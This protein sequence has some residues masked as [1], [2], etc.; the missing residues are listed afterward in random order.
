MSRSS[1]PPGLYWIGPTPEIVLSRLQSNITGAQARENRRKTEAEI[2]QVLAEIKTQGHKTTSKDTGTAVCLLRPRRRR[3]LF[4]TQSFQ[5]YYAI[6]CISSSVSFTITID[7]ISLITLTAGDMQT[8]SLLTEV[9]FYSR[10]DVAKL[11]LSASRENIR[12]GLLFS[13]CMFKA[14]EDELT[15]R[16]RQD[17]V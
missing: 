1:M 5:F 10:F 4:G 3:R 13:S 17:N 7:I 8:E 11:G 2:S 6:S 12:K 14:I 16:L 15:R 9:G